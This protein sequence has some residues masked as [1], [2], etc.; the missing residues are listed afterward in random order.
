MDWKKQRSCRRRE[1][2]RKGDKRESLSNG[3]GDL[4]VG[5]GWVHSNVNALN[6]AELHP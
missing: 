4:E 5:G 3:S 2:R 1:G 6:T